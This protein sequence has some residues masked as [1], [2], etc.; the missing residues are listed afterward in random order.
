MRVAV[1]GTGIMGFGMARN[2]AEAGH[3]LTAW[4]RTRAKAEPLRKAGAVV[5][6]SPQEAVAG[7]EALVTM[8][9]DGP[10][11]EAA[12]GG[13]SGALAAMPRGALWL[14]MSTVGVAATESLAALAADA[15]VAFVDA[16]VMGSRRQADA[17]ELYVLASGPDELRSRCSALFDA[18]ARETAWVGGVGAGN[19]LKLVMNNWVVCTVENI[20]ETFALA[21]ALALDPALFLR[22]ARESGLG[23]PYL[24]YKGE[25]MLKRDFSPN[26]PLALARKDLGLILEA[27]EGRV[28]LP[29]V[30][31]ACAQLDRAVELGH[32]DEDMAATYHASAPPARDAVE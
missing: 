8:L 6:R 32:G 3:H 18:V 25:A 24:E 7:A 28:E 22:T 16:P 14:Q 27:A 29:L 9:A 2:L 10:A 23:M 1:L 13:P 21:E 30:R 26:F 11:V 15:D 4:N 19:R 5:A 31:A 17:G 20:A 12:V